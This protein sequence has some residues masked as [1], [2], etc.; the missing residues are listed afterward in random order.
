MPNKLFQQS[1]PTDNTGIRS[2]GFSLAEL[3]IAMVIGVTLIAGVV[4]VAVTSKTSF[5][6]GEELSRMQESG[7]FALDVMTNDI[8]EA[9]YLGFTIADGSAS[10]TVTANP[11]PPLPF[12]SANMI[13][14]YQWDGTNWT[15]SAPT[16]SASLGAVVSN[17]DLITIQS[18]NSCGGQLISTMANVN[19]PVQVHQG[20]TCN[21]QDGDVVVLTDHTNID[22][23][24]VTSTNAP[25]AAKL[26]VVHSVGVGTGC[27]G[28]ACNSSNS[29]GTTY[30][31]DS[32]I[33]V[34]QSMTYFIRNGANGTPSLW[35]LNN[36]SLVAEELVEGVEDMEL[37]YGVDQHA[38]GTAGYGV[39]DRYVDANTV[40][41]DGTGTWDWEDVIAVRLALLMKT[42]SDILTTAQDYTFLA[43]TNPTTVAS[44]T[45]VTP[46][47][48]AAR[49]TLT[50]T[51]QLRNRGLQ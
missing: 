17:T 25:G 30:G 1:A 40:D 12:D 33:L 46:T 42:P 32:E 19:N 5:V 29:L 51:I 48:L 27:N 22:V 13:K 2:R 34:V 43:N 39:V 35:R 7:R 14:G 36:N 49:R 28:V 38:I 24:R 10:T 37:L 18:G 6:V 9:G 50:T 45:T 21:I 16:N 31:T 4:Q 3:M 23:F 15:P 44:A 47:D 41:V 8:R 11:A 26:N 20:N